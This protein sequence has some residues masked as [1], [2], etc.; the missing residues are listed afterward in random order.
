MDGTGKLEQ[1]HTE[2][3]QKWVR[4]SVGSFASAHQG[5]AEIFS[6]ERLPEG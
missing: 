1:L 3:W 5:P 4:S 2:D 6:L